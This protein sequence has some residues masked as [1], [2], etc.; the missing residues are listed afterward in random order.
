[1]TAL[2]SEDIDKA[3][4]GKLALFEDCATAIDQLFQLALDTKGPSAFDEFLHF[5]SGFNN[6]SVYNSMLV[7]VQRPGAAAVGSRRQ[8]AE[9]GRYM[10]PDAVPIVVLQPFGPVRF[11]F[12]IGDT[13]GRE[14][15]GEHLDT[16]FAHGTVPPQ[17]QYDKTKSAADKYRIEIVE[18]DQYGALLTGRAAAMGQTPESLRPATTG[19]ARYRIKVNAKHDLPTRFATRPIVEP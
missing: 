16:L 11:V 1:M 2:A 12:E 10:R 7:R 8:W 5:M 14:V 19:A 17:I 13:D 18:T 3:A 9:R 6:L 15:P 4:V